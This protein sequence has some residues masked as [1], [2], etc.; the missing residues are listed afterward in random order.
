M[1][2]YRE[3]SF[4]KNVGAHQEI[5]RKMEFYHTQNLKAEKLLFILVFQ[6]LSL[7]LKKYQLSSDVGELVIP[8]HRSETLLKIINHFENTVTKTTQQLAETFI[9]FPDLEIV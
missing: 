2:Y 3:N 8:D 5:L 4:A 9:L 6:K 1:L 7:K